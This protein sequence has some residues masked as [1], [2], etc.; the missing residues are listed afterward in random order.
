M[1]GSKSSVLAKN[2][3]GSYVVFGFPVPVLTNQTTITKV[4]AIVHVS[5]RYNDGNY[6]FEF[7]HYLHVFGTASNSS[8]YF[9]IAKV[10][11]SDGQTTAQKVADALPNLNVGLPY[12]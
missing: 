10:S 3:S 1:N 2:A 7:R 11:T 4:K 9:G 6:D 8:S 5:Q 12:L